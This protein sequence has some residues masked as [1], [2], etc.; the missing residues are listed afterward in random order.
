MRFIKPDETN[1]VMDNPDTG[2]NKWKPEFTSVPLKLDELKALR[3]T[4]VQT[5]LEFSPS[6]SVDEGVYNWGV[7]DEAVERCR[8]AGLKVLLMGPTTVPQWCPDDWYV[9]LAD[10][11]VMKD[12]DPRNP[13]QTWGCLSPWNSEARGWLR[14]YVRE[15]IMRYS[16]PDVLCINSFSQ[17]GE[18]M[19]PPAGACLY[20]TAALQEYRYFM[21]DPT[22]VPNAASGITQRWMFETL[23]SWVVTLQEMYVAGHP[24]REAFMSL[25]P[26]YW[27]WPASGAY[28]IAGYMRAILDEVRPDRLTHIVFCYF[29]NKFDFMY[30]FVQEMMDLGIDYIVG[31]EWPEGLLTHSNEAARLGIKALLTCPTHPYKQ[32]YT[33]EPWMLD[34]FRTSRAQ[35]LKAHQWLQ[36]AGLEAMPA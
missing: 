2:V 3:D 28:D 8:K 34:A 22:A 10:G 21:N 35:Q 20:D 16:A 13:V 27:G 1:I 15:F 6:A 11:T 19:L 30:R 24:S 26:V 4:G 29:D 25:H 9:R 14:E 18:S 23:R 17:E 5:V 32:R 12:H 7:T 31:S 33:V 36:S